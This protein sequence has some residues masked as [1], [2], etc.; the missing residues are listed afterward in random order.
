MENSAL[1]QG[2]LLL[3]N[4]LHLMSITILY[5]D[6]LVTLAS[7]IRHIW[8]HVRTF[9]SIIFILNRYIAFGGNVAVTLYSFKTLSGESCK[10]EARFRQILLV[11]NVI[12]SGVILTTRTYA[13]WNR[14]KRVLTIM[15]G[16]AAILVAVAC[17]AMLGGMTSS[18]SNETGC[19]ISVSRSA[20]IYEATA[21]EAGFIYDVLIFVLTV[22][23]TYRTPNV[24]LG[25]SNA[26]GSVNLI[27]LLLRDGAVYFAIMAFANLSNMLTYYLAD[28]S[29]RGVL[30]TFASSIS[31]VMVSRLMLN[32]Y[33]AAEETDTS[34]SQSVRTSFGIAR[35][36]GRDESVGLYTSRIQIDEMAIPESEDGRGQHTDIELGTV[37][38]VSSQ[39]AQ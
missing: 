30:S 38:E 12:L 8:A 16:S 23:R 4:Y 21:W 11:V 17:W 1:D 35:T 13:L 9:G 5:Y 18:A 14:S 19:H 36:P 26:G 7:E 22:L 32:L 33:E 29:L 39:L 34:R 25:K 2:D 37:G 20:G 10:R 28:D 27:Y 6:H 24:R 15:L 3:R 31:V